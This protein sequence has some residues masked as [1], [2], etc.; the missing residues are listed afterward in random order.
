M[1]PQENGNNYNVVSV[2]I[3]SLSLSSFITSTVELCEYDH[4]WA[5]KFWSY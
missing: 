3:G 5:R 4:R 1:M 2:M